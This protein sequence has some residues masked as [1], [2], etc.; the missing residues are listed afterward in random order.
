MNA[1]EEARQRALRRLGVRNAATA[2]TTAGVCVLQARGGGQD[3]LV[4][5]MRDDIT[6]MVEDLRTLYQVL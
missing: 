3:E 1:E 6:K 4:T 5:A 2:L